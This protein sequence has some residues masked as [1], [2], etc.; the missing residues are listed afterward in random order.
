LFTSS[1]PFNSS[2]TKLANHLTQQPITELVVSLIVNHEE[3]LLRALADT[4]AS[5]SIILEAYTSGTLPFIKQMTV[6]QPPGVKWVVSLLQ[7]KLGYACDIFTPKVQPQETNF[8]GIS[9]R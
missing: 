2:K 9:C 5:S 6:I 3:H 7:L 1:K 4:G 8:L